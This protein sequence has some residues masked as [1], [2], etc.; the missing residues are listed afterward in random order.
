MRTPAHSIPSAVA[1][2]LM[3]GAFAALAGCGRAA[4]NGT[5]AAST[6]AASAPSPHNADYDN[7]QAIITCYR[8]HGDPSAPD[9]NYDPSDGRW[10]LDAGNVPESAQRACQHLFPAADPSPP[11]SQP[12]FQALVRFAVCMRQQGVPAWPDP[13]PAGQFPLPPALLTK[14]PAGERARTACQRYIP[15]GGN[16]DVIAAP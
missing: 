2:V 14:T 16:I 11:V 8:Q 5:T 4:G 15:G 3:L 9:P 12:V 13:N 1:A 10:H 6:T 7:A